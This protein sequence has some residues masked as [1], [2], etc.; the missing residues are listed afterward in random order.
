MIN[1]FSPKTT[2]WTKNLILVKFD[3]ITLFHPYFL[4]CPFFCRFPKFQ[5]AYFCLGFFIYYN[6]RQG[7]PFVIPLP[8]CF[9][10]S[11]KNAEIVNNAEAIS[12]LMCVH[13]ASFSVTWKTHRSNCVHTVF[14]P[15]S[16]RQYVCVFIWIHFWERFL[17]EN[18]R[19]L[20]V[21]RRSYR[22]GIYAVSSVDRAWNGGFF[23]GGEVVSS[24]HMLGIWM[25]CSFSRGCPNTS[26]RETYKSAG[27]RDVFVPV[28]AVSAVEFNAY[29]VWIYLGS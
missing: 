25:G 26:L 9:A 15:F 27:L 28:L 8:N 17:A 18:S 6:L 22:I 24:W 20:S 14:I 16:R 13:L 12:E 11:K 23:W 2:I 10:A 7:L 29:Y 19:C 1:I 21:D 3:A 4:S 5:F